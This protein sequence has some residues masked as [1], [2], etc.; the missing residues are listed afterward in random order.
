M[1]FGD[2]LLCTS[3]TAVLVQGYT[4]LPARQGPQLLEI[5]LMPAVEVKNRLC[6]NDHAVPVETKRMLFVDPY[7][8]GGMTDEALDVSLVDLKAVANIDWLQ[9]A[10]KLGGRWWVSNHHRI[11]LLQQVLK[12]I[13]EQKPMSGRDVR[14]PKNHK[15]LVPHAD[16]QQD[17]VVPE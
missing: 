10:L 6:L 16:P 9:M 13:R 1:Y 12:L 5:M 11:P 8:L 2:H 14:M 7:N 17:P 15:C 4:S 3:F